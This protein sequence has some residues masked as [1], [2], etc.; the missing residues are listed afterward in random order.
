[1]GESRGPGS[2]V[3]VVDAEKNQ[4]FVWWVNIGSKDPGISRLCGAWVLDFDAVELP[5]LLAERNVLATKSG[6]NA[7]TERGIKI[8]DWFS[9][10]ATLANFED[11]LHSVERTWIEEN[12]SRKKLNIE[13][14]KVVGWIKKA[15]LPRPDFPRLP[16]NI[17]IENPPAWT[18]NDPCEDRLDRVL[19]VAHWL[20]NLFDL[21]DVIETMK[22]SRAWI[23]KGNRDAHGE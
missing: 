12:E 6:R 16:R 9:I 7:I 11:Q 8:E 13:N 1:M 17:D 19:S 23:Q 5:D 2:T 22:V 10:E 20:S 3:A 4:V 14:K 21:R 18:L 15:Q